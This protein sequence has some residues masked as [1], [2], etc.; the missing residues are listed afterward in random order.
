VLH[1]HLALC[2]LCRSQETLDVIETR[3]QSAKD[4]TEKAVEDLKKGEMFAKKGKK[5]RTRL[6]V[7]DAFQHGLMTSFICRTLS[8][9]R[10]NAASWP[11]SW[12]CSLRSSH[13]LS[14]QQLPTSDLFTLT[15]LVFARQPRLS[16][17]YHYEC[18]FPFH[19]F[20]SF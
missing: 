13:R 3:I 8:L 16:L 14:F 2:M 12:V 6:H 17:S 7:V 10:N 18:R 5:V 4:F 1:V 19:S 20:P 9:F 11:S 15:P